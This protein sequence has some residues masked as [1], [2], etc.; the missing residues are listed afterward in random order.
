MTDGKEASPCHE[1][2]LN[3]RWLK[4]PKPLDAIPKAHPG[5][6]VPFKLLALCIGLPIIVA[7]SI[8]MLVFASEK[9]R[10]PFVKYRYLRI[11]NKKFPW[12]DGDKS[13]F[14]NPKRNATSEGYEEEKEAAE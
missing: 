14:H 8:A 3:E 11:R 12:G 6:H 13:L 7:N 2:A 5:S 10:P 9:E 4:A 1:S